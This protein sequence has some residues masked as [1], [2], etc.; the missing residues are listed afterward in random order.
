MR[1]TKNWSRQQIRERAKRVRLLLLDV[2][3]VL[4]DGRIIYGSAGMEVLAFHVRDGLALKSAQA[5]GIVVGLVSARK[6]EAL[7]RR[8]EELCVSEVHAGVKDKISVYRELLV[9]YRLS[10]EGVAYVG[11]DLTDLPLLRATGLAIAVADAPAEVRNAAH[12]VTSLPGGK[13]AVREAV[14]WLLKSRGDWDR[15]C[16]DFENNR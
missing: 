1:V 9:R 2:D 11:D 15:V 12:L 16:A 14:E 10:D 3:G 5:A 6:S 4:T 7:F 8:A 13:G